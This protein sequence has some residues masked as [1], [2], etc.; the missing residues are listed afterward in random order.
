MASAP[1]ARALGGV[2]SPA[3]AAANPRTEAFLNT[4]LPAVHSSPR[5]FPF[6]VFLGR[7]LMLRRL[8]TWLMK[9]FS[10]TRCARSFLL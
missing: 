4:A 1:R 10:T 8:F 5:T 9:P 2:C 6:R 7:D 3:V